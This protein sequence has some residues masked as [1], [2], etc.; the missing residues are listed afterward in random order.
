MRSKSQQTGTIS[1]TVRYDY[2][3]QGQLTSTTYPS[4]KVIGYRYTQGRLSG[5][6]IDG[7]PLSNNLSYQPFGPVKGWQWGNGTAFTRSFD[8]DGRLVAQALGNGTRTV[9]YDAASR[10]T[11]LTAPSN[12]TLG[13]DTLDRLTSYVTSTTNQAYTYD[14]DGNRLTHTVGTTP[15]YTYSY[16]AIDNK[17]ISTS[18][19][20]AR[21]YTFDAAGNILTDGR[22]TFTYNAR[23][24]LA[25]VI[26]GVNTNTYFINGLGQR[27]RKN[28][29]GY[30]PPRTILSMTRQ[31]SSLVNTTVPVHRSRRRFILTISP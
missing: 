30:P 8:R 9:T 7:Q 15:A 16:P 27:V 1:K 19:P 25:K 14:A 23:G 4:G 31:A 10:I 12:Q 2:D 22:N 28:G 17:L 29:A 20:T 18:G 26:Y 6:T 11:G 5:M 21:S 24:R 13:Y 3:S